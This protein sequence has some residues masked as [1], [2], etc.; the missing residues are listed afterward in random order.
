MNKKDNTSNQLKSCSYKYGDRKGEE[1]EVIRDYK[2]ERAES[3][4]ID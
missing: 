3:F 1:K 4:I 2:R